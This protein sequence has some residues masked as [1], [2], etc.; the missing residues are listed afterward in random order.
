LHTF[1]KYLYGSPPATAVTP[2][3]KFL[4]VTLV[5]DPGAADPATAAPDALVLILSTRHR[6]AVAPGFDPETLRRL[7]EAIEARS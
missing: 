4:P 1:R 3:A 7:I 2:P 6:I 5:S